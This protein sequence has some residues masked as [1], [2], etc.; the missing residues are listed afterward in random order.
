[1]MR[2][3][4]TIMAR[5]DIVDIRLWLEPLNQSGLANVLAALE[6]KILLLAEHP[7]IGRVTENPVVREGIETRYGFLI[8]YMV[9]DGTLFV[10]RVYH[11]RREPLD[12]ALLDRS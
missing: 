10:L 6:R 2:I 8:P 12:Y 1:M 3:E 5:Q 7:G 9:R 4:F 11:S